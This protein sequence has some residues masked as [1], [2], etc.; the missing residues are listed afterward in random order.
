[1]LLLSDGSVIAKTGAGGGDAY[2]NVW[3]KLTPDTNGSYIN[4]SWSAIASMNDTRFYFATQVLKDG[5]VYAAGGEYGT[6]KQTAEIYD[7]VANTWS[8][9]PSPI[10]NYQDTLADANSE[11]L[12]DGTVMVA[13][14]LSGSYNQDSTMIYDPVSNS[15]SAGAASINSHDESTWVK[16]ADNSI[17]FVD[18]SYTG[19]I[20]SERYIPSL[21]QWVADADVPDSLYGHVDLETGPAL[22]LPDG[23][24]IFFGGAGHT[25]YYTPSGNSSPGSWAAGPDFPE[26]KATP[27]ASAAM[28]C[29][30]KILCPLSQQSITGNMYPHPTT[31]YEFD[32]LTNTF[33]QITAPNG[34][35]AVD[36]PSYDT[37]LLNLPNGQVLYS[38]GGSTYYVYTPSGAPLA[39]GKP[40]INTVT[41]IN[42]DTFSVTGTL[43]NGISEGTSFGDDW[44]MATNYP[45][46]QLTNGA[47]VYY[48]RTFNWNSTGVQRGSLPDNVTFA[49]PANLPYAIYSLAVIANGISSNTV[50]VTYG[51][52]CGSSIHKIA[53]IDEQVTIYPNPSNGLVNLKISEFD[54]SKTT[55]VEIFNT[56]GEYMHRQIIKSSNCQIDVS[57]LAEGIYNLSISSNDGT[58]NKKLV[59]TR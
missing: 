6:G 42:C 28:M 53:S 35:T 11:M 37:H 25:A 9:T 51:T 16:L 46:V 33:T 15:Y 54:N 50:S 38:D 56:I 5:R 32:Y 58:I 17:L 24:A 8:Y 31:Y 14:V 12:P 4:G 1:M 36:I 43:F 3:N 45:I 44:Q 39:A 7:P 47:Y 18:F 52:D 23:R 55:S 2:G 29:N 57:D 59:I 21:N 34:D 30:G 49:L 19:S 26:G 13:L 48:A 10:T 20:S 27:D 41:Q 22:L 40:T